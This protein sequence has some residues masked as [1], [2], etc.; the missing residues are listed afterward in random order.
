MAELKTYGDLKKIIKSIALKQ[1]GQQIGNVALDT[2]IGLIPGANA[3][4]TTFDFIKAAISKPDAKKTNTWLDKLDID[5]QMSAIVDDTVENGFM[6]AMSKSIE[7]ESDD[8]PLESDFNMN[9]RMVGFLQSKYKGRTIAGIKENK[10]MDIKEYIKTL[11]RELLDEESTTAGVPGYL[12]ANAFSPKG[13]KTNAATKTAKSQGMKLAPTGMPSDSKVRDYKAIWKSAEKPSY[14]MYKENLEKLIQEE[15]LNE[16]TY[17]QFKKEVKHRT[18]AEQLHKAMREVKKKIN[19]I[20]RIV[21]YTQR[22]KQELSEGDGVAYWGRTE[23]AVAQ[24]AEMV[25]HLTNKI[26]NLKQ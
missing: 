23:K 15:L 18:K 7:S 21:D 3:A 9:S 14:K 8:K 2:V 16:A 22:M 6:Q 12:S 20:D 17:K 13:Q 1:K 25:N 10:D 26:N 11:V 5:D 24:I 4:K 19:E